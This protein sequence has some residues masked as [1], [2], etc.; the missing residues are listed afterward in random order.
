MNFWTGVTLAFLIGLVAGLMTPRYCPRC[1]LERKWITKLF[2]EHGYELKPTD[3]KDVQRETVD[4]PLH[5][6]DGAG[7]GSGESEG[8][9]DP[10]SGM[11][12]PK[13]GFTAWILELGKRLGRRD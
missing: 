12:N 8:R 11:L 10:G 1:N 4:R 6:D 9:C 13:S 7:Q 2:K 5:V 3:T